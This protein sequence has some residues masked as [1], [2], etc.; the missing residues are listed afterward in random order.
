MKLA[1]AKT[2]RSAPS[3]SDLEQIDN[4]ERKPLRSSSIVT[5]GNFDTRTVGHRRVAPRR[6]IGRDL[7]L[8]A[9]FSHNAGLNRHDALFLRGV[10]DKE[11]EVRRMWL[12][13][14]D[15]RARIACRQLE[16]GDAM[17]AHSP[18]WP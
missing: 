14:I 6:P 3:I 1:R 5:L 9:G 8:L 17:L 10:P 12:D 7:H 16:R 18:R 4:T 15:H 13:A 2:F 11:R